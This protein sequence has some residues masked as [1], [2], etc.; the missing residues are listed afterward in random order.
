MNL[1]M[2]F[3]SMA[4]R[5]PPSRPS[6]KKLGRSPARPRRKGE[7][8]RVAGRKAAVVTSWSRLA[9]L[10]SVLPAEEVMALTGLSVEEV[11]AIPVLA[12]REAAAVA[13]AESQ[14]AARRERA[15]RAGGE[16]E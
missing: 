3:F 9:R 8:R 14:A 6:R 13:A 4:A 1:Q 11:A 7:S 16:G 2:P 12:A 10:A 5:F 15:E